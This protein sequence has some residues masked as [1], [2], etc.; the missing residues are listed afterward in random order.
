MALASIGAAGNLGTLFVRLTADSV[1]LVKGMNAAEVSVGKTSAAMTRQL[2]NASKI[3]VA[4]F[5]AVAAAAAGYTKHVIDAAD[6]TNKMAQIAG[7]AVDK[8]SALSYAAQLADLSQQDLAQASRFLTLWM[9]KQGMA[10]TDLTDEMVKQADVFASMPDGP[11]KLK[12]AYERFGRSG[13]QLIPL[14]NQG[15]A[16]LREQMEEA[17]QFGIVVGPDFGR[18]A[19]TFNDNLVRMQSGLKGIFSTL[20]SELLPQWIAMQER[21]ISLNKDVDAH[22]RAVEGLKTMYEAVVGTIKV[23]VLGLSTIWHALKSIATILAN[24]VM[25]WMENF[26][27]AIDSLIQ[28]GGVWVKTIGNIIDAFVLLGKQVSEVGNIFR[29]LQKSDWDAVLASV[30]QLGK[31]V[32]DAFNKITESVAAGIV[33]S[34]EIAKR[35]YERQM[36][37]TIAM[38]FETGND[39]KDIFEGWVDVGELMT[40]VEGASTAAKQQVEK[41]FA[42]I[43]GWGDQIEDIVKKLGV[44]QRQFL[45]APTA[46]A[47][48]TAEEITANQERLAVL[49]ELA[50]RELELTGQVHESKLKAIE[51]YNANLADLMQAQD[52]LILHSQEDMFGALGEMVKGFAGEQSA[53]YKAMF[54]ASKA[55]AIAESIVKI[56]QGVAAALSLG[57][58]LGLVAAA[59]VVTQAANIVST[60]QSVGL[61]IAGSREKG[62]PVQ[63]NKSFLVGEAGPE[64]FT[65]ASNGDIIPNNQLGNGGGTKVIINNYTDARAQVSERSEGD[66]RIVEVMIKRVK[67]ELGTEIRDGR[68]EVNRA[69]ENSFQLRRGTK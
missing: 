7:Q 59:S 37:A 23:F 1:D 17:R 38:A 14:L 54:A 51:A 15:S 11:E 57:W 21:F 5:A 61:T 64:I 62:G 10:A 18:N 30:K 44:P 26:K 56:Q 69:M 27:T 4:A 3:A 60:I 63:A 65:P 35:G 48:G 55:F 12:Q 41:D 49:E 40:P 29:A 50:A 28:I 31:G 52:A 2:A 20:A 47:F 58:P 9:E 46:Q 19:D 13:T 53:A 33:E 22:N 45:D 43:S 66:E 68:G 32:G 34:A 67:S 8:F 42:A 24:S 6:A 25:L 36:D 39:L 16:A